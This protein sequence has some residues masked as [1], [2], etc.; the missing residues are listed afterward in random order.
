MKKS[1]LSVLGYA[2]VL[3]GAAAT[4]VSQDSALNTQNGVTALSPPFKT[5][6][7]S[8]QPLNGVTSPVFKHGYLNGAFD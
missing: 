1:F 5:I 3:V 7:F 4:L 6:A 2:L 8:P